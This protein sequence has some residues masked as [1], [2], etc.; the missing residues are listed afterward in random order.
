MFISFKKLG[1]FDPN[2]IWNQNDPTLDV[3]IRRPIQNF[4]TKILTV[5]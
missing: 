1:R 2:N 3:D 4:D 5:H